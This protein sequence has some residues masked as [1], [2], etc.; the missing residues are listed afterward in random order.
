[1]KNEPKIFHLGAEPTTAKVTRRQ[2]EYLDNLATRTGST[3]PTE[4]KLLDYCTQDQMS[5]AIDEMK[6]GN[7]IIFK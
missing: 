5:F 2:C 1:M 3:I 4:R 6:R 7:K